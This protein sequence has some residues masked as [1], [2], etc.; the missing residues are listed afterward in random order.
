MADYSSL[1]AHL[2]PRLTSQVENAATDALAYIL[3]RSE[4][5]I[6]ALNDLLR[7]GGFDIEPIV[8]VETQVS[9]PDG[10]R[11]DMAGYDKTDAAR[12]LVEAKFWASLLEGQASWYARLLDQPG[13][14]TL[15]FIAPEP[16]LPTLWAE[17][18]RQMEQQSRLEPIESPS[19]MQRA[20]VIWAEQGET[21]IHLLLVSWV[22]LLDRIEVSSEDD[23]VKSDIRQLRGF[24]QSQGDKGFLPIG[25]EEMSP[26]LARRMFWYN[27]LVDDAVWSKGIHD[28][29]IDSSKTRATSQR[30]GY[31]TFFR[32]SE[33][34]VDFW[35][36]VNHDRWAGSGDTPLWLNCQW[37]NRSGFDLD[38]V[39]RQLNVQ[40]EDNWL[41][42]YLKTGVEYDE[43]LDGV[44]SQLKKIDELASALPPSEQSPTRTGSGN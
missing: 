35:F 20:K 26:S 40:F 11:P 8:R 1:M 28:G 33:S 9:Y 42:I 24:A 34:N 13:P 44:V 30:Y 16:R 14:A 2:V 36:G 38:E 12:L 31:G 23:G 15:L 41:P 19:G 22:R 25:S 6:Q 32:L 29:W 37:L 17:V 10:S 18:H 21:E 3:N 43:V 27:Q 7:E 5:A 39:G 4:G